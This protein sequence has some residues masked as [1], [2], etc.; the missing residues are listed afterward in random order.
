MR[1]RRELLEAVA[2]I[3]RKAADAGENPTIAV[4]DAYPDRSRRTIDR[5]VR[6]AREEGLLAPS[7]PGSTWLRTPGALAVAR[8]LGVSY[9]HLVIAIRDHADG[10][11]KIG[12]TE[13]RIAREALAPVS[14]PE[15]LSA[16]FGEVIRA[17]RTERGWSQK[18]LASKIGAALRREVTPLTI[19]R[20]EAGTRPVP[21]DE[22][23]AFAV[24]LN[25][26]VDEIIKAQGGQGE[27]R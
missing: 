10:Y 9:E 6:E 8:A 12:A 24:V 16:T 26:S 14:V 2:A 27:S 7:K 5:W 22:V 20:S 13:E 1:L 21:L 4:H 25:L 15:G 3:W 17:A 19:T 11:L 23:A 18:E